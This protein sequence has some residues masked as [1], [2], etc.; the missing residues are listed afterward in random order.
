MVAFIES[1]KDDTCTPKP[2]KLNAWVCISLVSTSN[3]NRALSHLSNAWIWV[4]ISQEYGVI[5]GYCLKVTLAQGFQPFGS[6]RSVG[7]HGRHLDRFCR[8]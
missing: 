2:A 1:L 7:T 5:W 6:S 8:F 3:K 4:M